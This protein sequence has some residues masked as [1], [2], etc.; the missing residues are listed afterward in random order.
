MVDREANLAPR[1]C[2]RGGHAES[3]IIVFRRPQTTLVP[4]QISKLTTEAACE[5][6]KHGMRVLVMRI[7]V[8]ACSIYQL[9]PYYIVRHDF[10][11][12]NK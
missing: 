11:G 6:V 9:L 3:I 4:D 2:G 12:L 7:I 8:Y 10:E 5:T 1:P